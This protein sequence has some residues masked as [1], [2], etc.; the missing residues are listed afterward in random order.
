ML[1]WAWN[2]G[3]RLDL[4]KLILGVLGIEMIMKSVGAYE[5]INTITINNNDLH[6]FDSLR[7]IKCLTYNLI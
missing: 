5:V 4:D 2:L 6:V 3:D 7:C 1:M